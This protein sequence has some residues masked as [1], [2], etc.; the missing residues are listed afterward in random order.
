MTHPYTQ[1]GLPAAL[2]AAAATGA[3]PGKAL[4]AGGRLLTSAYS[5]VLVVPCALVGGTRGAVIGALV[6]YLL[7]FA[8]QLVTSATPGQLTLG[9]RN[10]QVDTGSAGGVR[11]VGKD[12]LIGVLSQLSC[13]I[14]PVLALVFAEKPLNRTWFDRWTGL[15]VVRRADAE[16]MA[17][18]APMTAATPAPPPPPTHAS[19]ATPATPAPAPVAPI[20]GEDHGFTV[21]S[22]PTFVPPAPPT[23]APQP[24]GPVPSWALPPTAPPPVADVAPAP[25][26]VPPV[27]ATPVPPAAPVVPP[28]MP[29]APAEPAPDEE[30][31]HTVISADLVAESASVAPA[32]ELVLS[33]GTVLSL[34]AAWSIG[35]APR[36]LPGHEDTTL[37]AVDDS[38]MS[39][40]HLVVR[41]SADGAEVTDLHSSNGVSVVLPTGSATQL[42]PG[43]AVRVP[44]GSTLRFGATTAEVR[45]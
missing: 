18:P 31:D 6:W 4:R 16:A 10:V 38:G 9:L 37:A 7:S 27:P 36:H 23:P 1:P 14:V 44:T 29:S 33:T 19:L 26:Y 2:D 20:E 39:R 40:T 30:F 35:R 28:P 8:I 17:A 43:E 42:P 24:S 12:L 5:L 32:R 25:A 21:S 41:P 11:V 45:G 15:V 34:D 13:G 22:A 3:I